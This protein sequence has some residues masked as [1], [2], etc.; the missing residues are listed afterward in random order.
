MVFHLE[1]IRYQFLVLLEQ[2]SVKPNCKNLYKKPDKT[3]NVKHVR[4]L[5]KCLETF[6]GYQ[7]SKCCYSNCM[8]KNYHSVI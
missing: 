8:P 6:S 5:F 2:F 4:K 3:E 1:V 7:I